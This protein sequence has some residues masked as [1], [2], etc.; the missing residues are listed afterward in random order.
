MN[1]IIRIYRQQLQEK[2]L[3][4]I[5]IRKNAEIT[6]NGTTL[7]SNRERALANIILRLNAYH[8]DHKIKIEKMKLILDLH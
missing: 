6:L 1:E 8:Q 2:D 4:Q 3:P 5:E 7:V